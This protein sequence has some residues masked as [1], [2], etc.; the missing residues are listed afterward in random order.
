MP[1]CLF[2]ATSDMWLSNTMEPYTMH[3]IDSKWN[4]QSRC[5]QMLYTPADHTAKILA[6]RMKEILEHLYLSRTKQVY[7][8]TDSGTCVV[9]TVRDVG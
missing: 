1:S 4:L 5:L 7:T 2:S 6:D 9:K 8:T 3:V